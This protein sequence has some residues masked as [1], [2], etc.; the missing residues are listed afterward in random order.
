MEAGKGILSPAPSVAFQIALTPQAGGNANLV[1]TAKI[2]GAD[3]FTGFSA[4]GEASVIGAA[5]IIQ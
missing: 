3:E 4:N 1:G 5:E 2:T